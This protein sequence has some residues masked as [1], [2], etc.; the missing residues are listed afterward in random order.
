MY[1]GEGGVRRRYEGVN[2]VCE[3]SHTIDAGNNTTHDFVYTEP[4]DWAG[5]GNT[6]NADMDMA[7]LRYITM[8]DFCR[9]GIP[10]H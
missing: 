4:V 2:G 3:R 10:L 9:Y 1:M 5:M 6:I 7:L 8:L